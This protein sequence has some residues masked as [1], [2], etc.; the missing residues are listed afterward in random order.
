MGSFYHAGLAF[1][2]NANYLA[3]L[4]SGWLHVIKSKLSEA[5]LDPRNIGA[6]RHIYNSL[7]SVFKAKSSF[8]TE[9]YA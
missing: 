2:P 7:F 6:I 9:A 3:L 5:V 8:K 4:P 1:A